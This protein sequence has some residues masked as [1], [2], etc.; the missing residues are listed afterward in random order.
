MAG[1][2]NIALLGDAALQQQL[3]TLTDRLERTLLQAALSAG[4]RQ[5]VLPAVR[6]EA[7][8]GKP[9]YRIM[10]R[11]RRKGQGFATFVRSKRPGGRLRATLRPRQLPRTR[12]RVGFGLY[13]GTRGQLGVPNARG[14]YPAHIEYGWR[15]RNGRHVQ[16]RRYMKGPL[17]RTH[18]QTVTV[19]A[20]ALRAGIERE[21]RP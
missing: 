13:T 2:F 18:A 17:I 14:Y 10:R 3:R 19:V 20:Q 11:G 12:R 7:P 15:M 21:V 5:V 1:R 9:T 16:G 6:A 4:I 8:V